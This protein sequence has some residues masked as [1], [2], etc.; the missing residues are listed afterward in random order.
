[1]ETY[2]RL[3]IIRN[4]LTKNFLNFIIQNPH[5]NLYK[6]TT[7]KP[8]NKLKNINVKVENTYID[9]TKS[10][11]KIIDVME[12]CRLILVLIRDN[13]SISIE[14][15]E[16]MF[17]NIRKKNIIIEWSNLDDISNMDYIISLN[18]KI[19][20]EA[21]LWDSDRIIW[22]QFE[23][24]LTQKYLIKEVIEKILEDDLEYLKEV[25]FSGIYQD[26]LFSGKWN[27]IRLLGNQNL[28]SNVALDDFGDYEPTNNA[29]MF[30]SLGNSVN[31]MIYLLKN[32]ADITNS[33]KFQQS[34]LHIAVLLNHIDCVAILLSYDASLLKIDI[35]GKSP[36]LYAKEKGYI[37]CVN[38]IEKKM[39]YNFDDFVKK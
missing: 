15:I 28:F 18:R 16:K 23:R 32:N 2:K 8:I 30:C 22:P 33:N 37:E 12:A 24:K 1:M 5:E 19:R 13:H 35:Y 36:L 3:N 20:K 11:I 25:H 39:I 17:Q 31:C 34:A 10:D 14:S 7:F 9:E 29:L 26:F 4:L 38:M 27:P 6:I 21:N